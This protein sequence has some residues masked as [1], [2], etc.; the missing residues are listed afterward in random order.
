M[1]AS[2]LSQLIDDHL[3][4][5]QTTRAVNTAKSYKWGLAKFAEF[6]EAT[7][8]NIG[9]PA[10]QLTVEVF[11]RFVPWLSRQKLAKA[12]VLNYAS[13]AKSLFD[14]LVINGAI[15]PSQREMLRYGMAWKEL[16]KKREAKLPKTPTPEDVE[17]I[18]QVAYWPN[19][20]NPHER[21]RNIALIET[22]ICTGCRAG[23]IAGLQ[24][25]AVNLDARRAVV[26]GKGSKERIVFLSERAAHALL[27]YWEARRDQRYESYAFGR[28]DYGQGGKGSITTKTIWLI[29]T[30]LANLAGIKK[31]SPHYFRHAFATRVLSATGNL[32]AV[33]D[34]LGHASPASTRVYAKISSGDLGDMHKEIYR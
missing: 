16:S 13:A 11:I 34:M 31:F 21:L 14:S 17:A 29:V 23:E 30:T 5:L 9:G 25:G 4:N 32:A 10:R 18:R 15:E 26:T 33:Q 1:D 19:E 7:D 12:S 2:P 27:A 6:L 24:V 8:I 20:R 22:L 28:H 3:L